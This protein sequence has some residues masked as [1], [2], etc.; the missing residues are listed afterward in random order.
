MPEAAFADRA[1]A[2]PLG[3]PA[4]LGHDE[5]VALGVA[6]AGLGLAGSKVGQLGASFLEALLSG[7]PVLDLEAEILDAGTTDER[8]VDDPHRD[9]A[10]GEKDRAIR[11]AAD[12][13]H[14]Q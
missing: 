7:G 14:V 10:V 6:H 11:F 1:G 4:L 2:L 5:Q 3:S 9:V 12:F 13:L 8:L